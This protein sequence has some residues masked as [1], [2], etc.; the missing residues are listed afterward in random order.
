MMDEPR[1]L[2]NPA[3]AAAR[4]AVEQAEA[5]L[6]KSRTYENAVELQR[7]RRAE[8]AARRDTIRGVK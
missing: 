7:A 6:S 3:L 4:K 2:P 5:A 1:P 8:Q